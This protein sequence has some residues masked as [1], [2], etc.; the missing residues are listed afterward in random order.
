MF[1][2][3]GNAARPGGATTGSSIT[4]SRLSRSMVGCCRSPY[5]VLTVRPD[6]RYQNAERDL[7]KR[8][9]ELEQALAASSF[10]GA[11]ELLRSLPALVYKDAE[12]TASERNLERAW[13]PVWD[14]RIAAARARKDGEASAEW[15]ALLRKAQ[16]LAR[17]QKRYAAIL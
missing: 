4:V 16:A 17:V 8:K 9:R 1:A 3:Y 14:A 15:D 2:A 10:T 7:H 11:E 13:I 12:I 6:R 5:L